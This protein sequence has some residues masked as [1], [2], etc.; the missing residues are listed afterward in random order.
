M[1]TNFSYKELRPIRTPRLVF[2]RERTNT[3]QTLPDTAHIR[4]INVATENGKRHQP[5]L[6]L[7][8]GKNCHRPR[9]PRS[10]RSPG[11]RGD[12]VVTLCT[13]CHVSQVVAWSLPRRGDFPP[14][15]SPLA[16][17]HVSTPT[18][19]FWCTPCVYILPLLESL[20]TY[21]L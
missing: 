20:G 10:I 21:G 15:T 11:A 8:E 4:S 9:P 18:A 2:E 13:S 1:K 19:S 16:L 17:L 7:R 3:L 12:P 5:H 6:S 14:I